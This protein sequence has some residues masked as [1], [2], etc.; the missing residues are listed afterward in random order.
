MGDLEFGQKVLVHRRATLR[1]GDTGKRY[2]RGPVSSLIKGWRSYFYMFPR[3][4]ERGA[5]RLP[6]VAVFLGYRTVSDGWT[7][8]DY[9]D[10]PE[11]HP[12]AYYRVALVCFGP[13]EKPVYVF[14]SQVHTAKTAAEGSVR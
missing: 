13:R 1:R 5:D 8:Y 10:G 4:Q 7:E 2:N 11:Y 9:E 14:P 3:S 6:S 12:L